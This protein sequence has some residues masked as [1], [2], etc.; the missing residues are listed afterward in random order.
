MLCLAYIRFRHHYET[1]LVIRLQRSTVIDVE[2]L[3]QLL[4]RT[5]FDLGSQMPFYITVGGHESG[6]VIR[7]AQ[8]RDCIRNKVERE[9][10][11]AQSSDDD[12]LLLRADIRISQFIVKDLSHIDDLGT[13]LQ[14][15]FLH[16]V[17]KTAFG[18]VSLILLNVVRLVHFH[19]L[20]Q[21]KV[22]KNQ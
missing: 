10:E 5:K 22:I 17:P 20:W 18:I 15:Y 21:C 3:A 2:P 7:K 9:N 13:R 16:L 4:P 11:I 8:D 12:R 6:K 19:Y 1:L 14:G